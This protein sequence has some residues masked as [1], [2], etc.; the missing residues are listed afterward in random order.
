LLAAAEMKTL[1]EAVSDQFKR[2]S[3]GNVG[4]T[5]SIP[6]A[7][8]L[9]FMM[10][11]PFLT[12][13]V[14]AL[15]AFGTIAREWQDFVGRRLK[16]DVALVERLARCSRPDHVLSTYTDFWRRAGEDYGKEI[17]TMTDLMTD[18]AGKM[19]AAAQSSTDEATARMFQRR[20]A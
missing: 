5:P 18:M 11:N 3:A 10:G 4:H 15:G 9:A 12:G 16:E 2:G 1:G 14:E 6:S 17:T 20:A 7:P 13:D 8:G 19:A